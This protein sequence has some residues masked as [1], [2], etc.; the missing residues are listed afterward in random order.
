MSDRSIDIVYKKYLEEPFACPDV[1]RVE[2]LESQLQVT[3][4]V[5]YRE[6]LLQYNGGFFLEPEFRGPDENCPVDQLTY[7]HGLGATHPSAELGKRRDI[8][9]IDDNLPVKLLPIGYTLMGNFIV[10]ATREVDRGVILLKTFRDW[11]FLSD[12][13]FRFFTLLR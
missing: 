11:H 13:I 10:L 5:D 6:F 4:P 7:L 2:E 12:D 1:A 3:L 8:A 9:I